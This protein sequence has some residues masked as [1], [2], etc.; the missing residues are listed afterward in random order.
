MAGQKKESDFDIVSEVQSQVVKCV[1]LHCLFNL[2]SMHHEVQP[3][4]QSTAA[5]TSQ[6]MT[7][8]G[9]ELQVAEMEENAL[10]PGNSQ[11]GMIMPIG[12]F[13]SRVTW[14]CKHCRERIS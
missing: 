12:K 13:S 7:E 10:F 11:G 14:Q 2:A 5:C 6:E 4:L 9:K 3:R 8:D 1:I